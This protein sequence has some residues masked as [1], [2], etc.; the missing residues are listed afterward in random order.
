LYAVVLLR[1]YSAASSKNFFKRVPEDTCEAYNYLMDHLL[2][3]TRFFFSPKSQHSHSALSDKRKSPPCSIEKLIEPWG[4]VPICL[5]KL[6]FCSIIRASKSLCIAAELPSF[7]FILSKLSGIA[8]AKRRAYFILSQFDKGT[9]YRVRHII[10]SGW[11]TIL[12]DLN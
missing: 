11:I 10:N 1:T 6:S 2:E 3:L 5:S 8:R 7:S 9:F 12:E 4:G